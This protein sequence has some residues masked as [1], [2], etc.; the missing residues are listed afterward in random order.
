MAM[1]GFDDSEAEFQSEGEFDDTG[2][3]DG[4]DPDVEPESVYEQA[5]TFVEEMT[6]AAGRCDPLLEAENDEAHGEVESGPELPC[7]L[8]HGTGASARA[9][10]PPRSNPLSPAP[11]LLDTPETQ[12]RS[13]GS[14]RARVSNGSTSTATS[15]LLAENSRRVRIK[16][17]STGSGFYCQAEDQ[18]RLELM[19]RLVRDP[20]YEKFR[21]AKPQYRRHVNKRFVMAKAR[22]LKKLKESNKFKLSSG[23][24]LHWSNS[25]SHAKQLSSHLRSWLEDGACNTSLDEVDRGCYINNLLL[26]HSY[27][28]AAPLEGTER[29][30]SN[31]VLLTWQ[32]Q[33]G[34]IS[35]RELGLES[36]AMLEVVVIKLTAQDRVQQLWKEFQEQMKIWADAY[37]LPDWGISVELCTRTLQTQGIVR[38]HLH[39]W[40]QMTERKG[41]TLLHLKDFEYRGSLP[42]N[43]SFLTQ[44]TRGTGVAFAGCFYVTV[45]KIGSLFATSTKTPFDDYNVSPAWI[46]TLLAANKLDLDTAA[47]MY[48]R[49][50]QNVEHNIKAL[51]TV[52]Q[53]RRAQHI[54]T[55]RLKIEHLIRAKQRPFR[56][57]PL[58]EEWD[59]Q[60]NEV[61]DRYKF[62]VLDGRSRTGKSRFAANRT[63]PEKFLNVDCS[64]ATQPDLR[65]FEREV[66]DVVL[67]DEAT[68]ELVLRVKKLA[69][70]SIDEVRLGQSAT[71]VNSYVV[72]FHRIRLIVA[73]NVWAVSLSQ[74]SAAD[75]DWLEANSFYVWVDAPLHE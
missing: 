74:C 1:A 11:T 50:I 5:E 31:S 58:V 26:T 56:R 35:V 34:Q 66:H 67:W 12:S 14:S 6:W 48:V 13:S 72:W 16:T 42:H 44:R 73:S 36:T 71:N 60:Y 32:G 20:A 75:K 10:T 37:V 38:I 51:D 45:P 68:P 54:R 7:V 3:F 4:P 33:W 25:G 55:E 65:I 29:L 47:D 43:S 27:R 57:I 52:R 40:V 69:Q 63:S 23:K 59:Q 53:H 21:R 8:D 15:P 61:L 70:A 24:I 2:G 41:V 19:A 49:C 9:A 17:K 18:K 39:A 62:L 30:R 28:A 64:S 46:T 22:F